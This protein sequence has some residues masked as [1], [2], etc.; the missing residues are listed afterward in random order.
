V[1]YIG[2][3]LFYRISPSTR[4]HTSCIIER[5]LKPTD[6]FTVTEFHKQLHR[7]QQYVRENSETESSL[8]S[9]QYH[10]I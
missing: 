2:P 3:I 4:P 7:V 9:L 10:D 5:D 6:L 1:A 8:F